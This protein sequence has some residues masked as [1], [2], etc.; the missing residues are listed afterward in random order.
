MDQLSKGPNY[1][2]STAAPKT[3]RDEFAMA[4][5]PIVAAGMSIP[6]NLGEFTPSQFAAAMAYG[7]AD[8]MLKER[9]K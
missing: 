5:M 6:Q 8:A 4:A 9:A 2:D 3:L 1:D 7:I